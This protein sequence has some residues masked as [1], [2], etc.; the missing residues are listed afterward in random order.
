[1]F[2]RVLISLCLIYIPF[3]LQAA[4][5]QDDNTACPRIISQS[6]Y[7]SEMLDYLGLGHCI[8]GVSRYSKRDLPRTGGILDPDAEAIDALMPDLFITSNWTKEETIKKVVPKG[9]KVLRL[10]SFNKM[11]QL[12]ENMEAVIQA[13]N[14]T[15]AQAKVNEFAKAW[16]HKVKQVKG[17]NKKVLLLSSCSGKPYSFG[18]DSRLHDLFTKAGFNVA[19]S[20][21]KIRHIRP[22][23]EIENLNALANKY[24]PD[25]LIIFE[26]KQKQQC[27]MIM[28]KVPVSI[29]IFDGRKFLQPSTVILDGLDLLISKKHR[30]Q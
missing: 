21:G 17:N 13:T 4:N 26:Q 15:H 14:W 7:I 25:F 23:Q 27:Q 20:K 12:E 30:W 6:P 1:M 29:L 9:T 24:Q 22:G 8:V 11:S 18:P 28:P 10:A 5:P 16:R 19:E 2:L 3:S